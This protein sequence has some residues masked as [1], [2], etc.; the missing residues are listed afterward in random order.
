MLYSIHC[1]PRIHAQTYDTLTKLTGRVTTR[2]MAVLSFKTREQ[3]E[4]KRSHANCCR[5]IDGIVVLLLLIGN[6]IALDRD[7]IKV[8]LV[9]NLRNPY[10]WM[11]PDP[12]TEM[13]S[14]ATC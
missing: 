9:K 2:G 4:R 11:I 6:E 12:D 10:Y 14:V 8:Q 1:H 13:T 7:I 5:N 3:R